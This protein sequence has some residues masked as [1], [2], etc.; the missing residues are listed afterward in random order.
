MDSRTPAR[1]EA[2]R[3]FETMREH[4]APALE[5]LPAIAPDHPLKRPLDIALALLGLALSL[6]IW[7]VVAVAILVERDGSIIF[8]QQRWG[9]G[10]EPFKLYKFRTM[11]AHSDRTPGIRQAHHDDLR[12]TRT[13]R[14][15]RATGMDELPQLVNILK[16]DMS[17]VG[18]RALALG[19]VVPDGAGGWETYDHAPHFFTRLSVRPGLTSLATVHLPKDAPP[20][21]KFLL[22]IAYIENRSLASDLK[23]IAQSLWI[24]VRGRWENRGRKI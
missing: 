19:E 21:A 10:G 20:D 11:V 15:V 2:A 13:G 17:F 23:L 4:R 7:I 24:S 8:S 14:F 9:Y 1:Y 12:V 18:P 22:D 6:P 16:G 5:P 3:S